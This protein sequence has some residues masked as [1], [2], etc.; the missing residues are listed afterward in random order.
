MEGRR[1]FAKLCWQRVEIIRAETFKPGT[2]EGSSVG[3]GGEKLKAESG[4][5]K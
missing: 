3:E 5:L 2:G 4:K 1:P